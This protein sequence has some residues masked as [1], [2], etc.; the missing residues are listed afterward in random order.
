[1]TQRDLVAAV[2]VLLQAKQLK[3]AERLPDA[4]TLVAGLLAIQLKVTAIAHHTFGAW[5]DG[6]D[7]DLA[8]APAL[9]AW[10]ALRVL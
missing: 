4:A 6:A 5:R 8:L 10:W 2:Q 1:V 9:A 3:I 7:D